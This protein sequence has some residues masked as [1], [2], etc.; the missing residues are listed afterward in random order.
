[1]QNFINFL[2]ISRIIS[3]PVIFLL[4]LGHQYYIFAFLIF[5]FAGIT[6]YF[7]GFLARK[8]KL[9]SSIGEVLDPI[10][11]KILVIFILISISI[12]LN[13]FYIGFLSA[14][15]LSRE[16][17]VAA[18]RDINSRNNNNAATEVT[19]LAKIKTTVQMFTISIYLFSL[20]INNALMLVLS[21]I[22][23]LCATFITA[24][25]GII[26]TFKTFKKKDR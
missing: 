7:D 26:Y 17:W 19:F 13:S 15:I 11:D 22:S 1:M 14:I 4:L 21:D 20:A 2:T 24:Y 5:I 12:N 23:L 6:D 18:L 8:Y 9:T 3:A 16:V 25:T 10:A